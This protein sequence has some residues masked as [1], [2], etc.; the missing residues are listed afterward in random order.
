MLP[1]TR[2]VQVGLVVRLA[3]P[4]AGIYL[5]P[6]FVGTTTAAGVMTTLIGVMRSGAT[7]VRILEDRLMTPEQPDA[8]LM[9]KWNIAG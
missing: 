5:V 3:I 6:T 1:G 4:C 8:L 2:C 7:R 9:Q